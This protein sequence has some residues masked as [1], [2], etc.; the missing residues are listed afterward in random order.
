MKP[1][2]FEGKH[3]LITG[4]SG[5]LGSAI[6][7]LLADRGAQLVVSSRSD[8][9]LDELG[10]VNGQSANCRGEAE[11]CHQDDGQNHDRL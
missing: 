5:G 3:V 4:A 7:K 6:A 9:A 1:Y 8:K 11:K 2:S 10:N